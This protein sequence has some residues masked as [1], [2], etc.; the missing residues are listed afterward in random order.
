GVTGGTGYR[1]G[2]EDD[3]LTAEVDD[4]GV[5]SDPGTNQH[6]GARRAAAVEG[7]AC[8]QVGRDLAGW[9]GGQIRNP[10]ASPCR[11]AIRPTTG[12][13]SCWRRRPPGKAPRLRRQ[14][15]G[16]RWP[17]TRRTAC[18]PGSGSFV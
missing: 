17:P 11:R 3:E 16:C 8:Q 14:A 12:S 4:R 2:R 18:P 5:L 10:S 7:E 15:S 13:C 1:I 6:V 9:E